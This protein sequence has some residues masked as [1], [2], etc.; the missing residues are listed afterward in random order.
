VAVIVLG[1]HR[2]GTS[3]LA[4][5]LSF[6]GFELPHDAMPPQRDNPKGFWEPQGVVKLNNRIL[7]SLGGRWDRPGPFYV[8]GRSLVESRVAIAG[9]LAEKWL[10]DAIATLVTSYGN[11]AAIILKDPRISLLTS[12]WHRAL[13]DIGYEQ[14]YVLCYRHPLEVASSLAYRE[15]MPVS[16]ALQLWTHYSLDP[17]ALVKPFVA[18]AIFYGEL[19]DDSMNALSQLMGRVDP[20]VPLN[21]TETR[22]AVSGYLSSADRHHF[23]TESELHTAGIPPLVRDTWRLLKGWNEKASSPVALGDE[24]ENLRV[25]FDEAALFA[26]LTRPAWGIFTGERSPQM[27]TSEPIAMSESKEEASHGVE[28]RP[29]PNKTLILHYHLFKNAGTSLDRMLKANF[30]DA[31]DTAEF[32]VCRDP[33]APGFPSNV[34]EVEA[35][36]KLRHELKA[37][38]SH[39]ALLP[40]PEIEGVSVFPVLFIRHPVDRL[41]SA[42][43]FE[44]RQDASTY[45]A[46][47]AKMQDFPGYL[48][49]LI[50]HPINRA[51]RNFQTFRLAMNE[52]KSAGSERE[53]ALRTLNALEFVGLVE[54][55]DASLARLEELLAPRFPGFKAVSVRANVTQA[56]HEGLGE[57]L[58][59]IRAEI[60]EALFADVIAANADDIALFE[61][62]AARYN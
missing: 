59:A 42:Y 28:K 22:A 10:G 50:D 36:L 3:A 43:L 18:G 23:A 8:P 44:R 41:K 38:S 11:A 14:R 21:S 56:E 35:F 24:I 55:Y 6:H 12:L 47:L 25:R 17:L 51:A 32:D 60:G 1:M 37:F 26:G 53:R 40:P 33:K 54:A 58:A 62:T 34:A 52:P 16:L 49:E 19:L 27:K 48:R 13:G 4:R 5:T 9:A 61:A 46:R 2:S 45:G 31:W 29:S 20:R 39:T 7:A 15:R 57:K 30:G